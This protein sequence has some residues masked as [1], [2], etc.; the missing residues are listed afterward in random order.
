M[1]TDE[2]YLVVFV[3][4]QLLTKS[5]LFFLCLYS[6]HCWANRCICLQDV[7]SQDSTG[8]KEPRWDIQANL[9][10]KA[11]LGTGRMPLC[12]E[13]FP[14]K[15]LLCFTVLSVFPKLNVFFL[16]SAVHCRADRKYLDQ[17]SYWSQYPCA[18]RCSHLL[19]YFHC[20]GKVN[21][22]I[23]FHNCS[24]HLIKKI[25]SDTREK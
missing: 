12:Q 17:N 16:A 5:W 22:K 20:R 8:W 13:L 21:F 18:I 6:P 24:I 15:K 9:L 1:N 2:C 23:D 19:F 25:T 11:G 10:L 4:K 14:E 3:S 7:H